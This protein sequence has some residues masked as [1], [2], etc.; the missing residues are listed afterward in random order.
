MRETLIRKTTKDIHYSPSIQV[1]KR[2]LCRLILPKYEKLS[3][4]Y[5]LKIR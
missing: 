3:I 5:N 4:R 2:L 1:N